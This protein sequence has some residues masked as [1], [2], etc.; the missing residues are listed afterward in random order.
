MSVWAI[1][2]LA[3]GV[4][5]SSMGPF[6]LAGILTGLLPQI[7][8]HSFVAIAQ[9][10]I[11]FCLFTGGWRRWRSWLLFGVIANAIAFPQLFPYFRRVSH[12]RRDFLR[13]NPIWNTGQ[14]RGVLFAPITL[15]WR[16]LGVFGAVALV[17]GWCLATR[18]QAKLYCSSLAVF[19]IANVIRYQPWELDNTKLLYSAW[20]PLALPFVAQFLAALVTRPRTLAGRAGGGLVLLVFLV[21]C[22]LSAL[23]STVQSMF[24]PTS[25]FGHHD[26]KFGL[27]IAENTPPDAVVLVKA[28]PGTTVGCIAGR[29]LFMG[30]SG[31]VVSHGLDAGRGRD[32]VTMFRSPNNIE[33]FRAKNVSY[34]VS[35]NGEKESAFSPGNSPHWKL[36]YQDSTYTTWRRM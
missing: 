12:S 9:F 24:W 6:V 1:L 25:M 7:Q 26:Y 18:W 22:S 10:S 20:V 17:F 8:V 33:L 13:L 34:V 28:A 3:L 14:K 5:H 21:A 16:G 2:C 19:A 35:S 27:W 4:E 30:F 36:V 15:W 31:W 23:M 29:Q 32:E 11:A